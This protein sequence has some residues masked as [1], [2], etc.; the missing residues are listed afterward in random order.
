MAGEPGH[1]TP[2]AGRFRRPGTLEKPAGSPS[3]AYEMEISSDFHELQGKGERVQAI[4]T[5]ALTNTDFSFNF[6]F[7]AYW[8]CG[9]WQ[10]TFAIQH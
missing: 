5:G 9:L 2:G 10:V 6:C 4:C 1:S 3:D 8:L 7:T